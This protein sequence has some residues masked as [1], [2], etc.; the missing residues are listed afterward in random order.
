VKVGRKDSGGQEGRLIEHRLQIHSPGKN[1][2]ALALRYEMHSRV[3]PDKNGILCFSS[4]IANR[5][6]ADCL[7]T[8]NVRLRQPP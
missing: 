6:Q 3:K 1:R 5:R 7:S 4:L 2:T 8:Q